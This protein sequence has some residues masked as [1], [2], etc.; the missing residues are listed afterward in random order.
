PDLSGQGHA[1]LYA[2]TL[3]ATVRNLHGSGG[4]Q[5]RFA[6]TSAS[7]RAPTSAS[8][9]FQYSKDRLSTGSL[10]LAREPETVSISWARWAS[11]NT[12]RTRIP[13]CEKSSSPSRRV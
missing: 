13:A 5:A 12:S 7:M 2:T 3:N 9:F 1:T 10:T 8:I 6:F 11:L 4:D